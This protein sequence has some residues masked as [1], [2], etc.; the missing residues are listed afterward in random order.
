MAPDFDEIIQLYIDS[1]WDKFDEDLSGYL[2][3]EECFNF[4]LESF[5][6][7]HMDNIDEIAEK[8]DL[9]DLNN[10]KEQFDELYVKLDEDG[11]GTISK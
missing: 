3:K 5:F 4:I 2:D 11:S 1:I 7:F 8:N 9:K 6:S 10:F